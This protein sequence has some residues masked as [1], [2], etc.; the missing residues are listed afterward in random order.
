MFMFIARGGGGGVFDGRCDGWKLEEE[1]SIES[2]RG[3]F[4]HSMIQFIFYLKVTTYYLNVLTLNV[5]IHKFSRH[6]VR[7]AKR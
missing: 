4:S 3:T 1:K 7:S 5:L 6:K 2:G